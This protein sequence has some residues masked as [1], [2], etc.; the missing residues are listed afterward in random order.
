M[1]TYSLAS[2]LSLSLS[3]YLALPP[4]LHPPSLSLP[5]TRTYSNK[6]NNNI[7]KWDTNMQ[8]HI[9]T[10]ELFP[11]PDPS[12]VKQ[13]EPSSFQWEPVESQDSWLRPGWALPMSY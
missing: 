5:Q 8:L 11:Q 3:L 12:P 2:S 13:A 7:P 9:A 4:S 1:H 10:Y 6:Y